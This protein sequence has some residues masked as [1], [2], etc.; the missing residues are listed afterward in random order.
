VQ[1]PDEVRVMAFKQPANVHAVSFTSGN[2]ERCGDAT[3]I[4]VSRDQNETVSWPL[5]HDSSNAGYAKRGFYGVVGPPNACN[6]S[7][8]ICRLVRRLPGS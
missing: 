6:V 4:D 2:K 5:A 3:A 1:I 8:V 7:E